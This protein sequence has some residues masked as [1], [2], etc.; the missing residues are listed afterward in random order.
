MAAD[1]PE[2]LLFQSTIELATKFQRLY[3]CFRGFLTQVCYMQHHRKL[4]F[5]YKSNMAAVKPEI[6]LYQCRYELE[7]K[8]QRLYPCFRGTCPTQLFIF[9]IAGS[10]FQLQIQD[11][12]RSVGMHRK[13]QYIGRQ[14][15]NT[16]I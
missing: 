5:N 10:C 15:G 4:F 9:N 16:I 13:I 11:G 1:K 3:P 7:T 12:G 8:F 14:T 6:L 2:V